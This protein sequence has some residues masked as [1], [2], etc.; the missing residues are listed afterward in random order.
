MYEFNVKRMIGDGNCFFHS[1][2]YCIDYENYK[3]MSTER[4]MIFTSEFKKRLIPYLEMNYSMLSRGQLSEISKTLSEYTLDNLKKYLMSSIPVDSVFFEIV[5][6][7]VNVNIIIFDSL[8][9]KFTY[10]DKDLLFKDR[11][12]IVLY[13][14]DGHYDAME[15]KGRSLFNVKEIEDVMSD[16]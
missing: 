8:I 1:V 7:Y 11:E 14:S 5:C 2:L 3:N 9:K 6:E 16:N 12:S 15:I 4:R 10:I 13:Y